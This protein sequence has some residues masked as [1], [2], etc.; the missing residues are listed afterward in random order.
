MLTHWWLLC[1]AT[2]HALAHVHEMRGSRAQG[3]EELAGLHVSA[4]VAGVLAALL[5]HVTRCWFQS[6][7]KDGA[8]LKVHIHWHLALFELYT[9]QGA[10]ALQRYDRWLREARAW[11]AQ[12]VARVPACSPCNAR[13]HAGAHSAGTGLV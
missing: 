4:I 9:G 7:W 8:L 6:T 5:L 1:L 10:A 2:V 13:M 3:L 12:G 11:G